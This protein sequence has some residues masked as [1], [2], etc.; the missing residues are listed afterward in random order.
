MTEYTH[1]Q[2]LRLFQVGKVSA[3]ISVPDRSKTYDKVV[4]I[5]HGSGGI[6]DAEQQLADKLSPKVPVV[7]IDHFTG[8]GVFSHWWD[9]VEFTPS[10]HDRLDDVLM[11]YK[12]LGL[13]NN[14]IKLQPD[15][16][17]DIIGFSAGGTVAILA[18]Q[19]EWVNNVTAF[20]PALWPL[21]N[22]FDKMKQE[23]IEIV[24]GENDD[25]TPLKHA[26]MFAKQYADVT[27]HILSD[28]KHGFMKMGTGFMENS[29]SFRDTEFNGPINDVGDLV[30]LPFTRGIHVEYHEEHA[31]DWHNLLYVEYC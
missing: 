5:C 3:Q 24:T 29:I 15:F 6:G 10:F 8:R 22:D 30:G 19:Y 28:T 11:T 26:N 14:L 2:R 16:S 13:I 9:K 7:M 17:V 1:K 4:I 20:Y 12:T 18:S 23:K 25:W 21:L 27:M 31:K